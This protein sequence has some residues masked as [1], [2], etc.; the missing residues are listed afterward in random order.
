MYMDEAR[1][2]D[3]LFRISRSLVG[4][5]SLDDVLDQIV[6]LTADLVSSKICALMLLDEKGDSLVIK[7][8]QSLSP[9]YK[10]KLPVK[11]GE[12]IS[13]RVIKN[14]TPIQVRDVIADERYSYGEVARSEGLKSLLSVPMLVGEIPIGV[15]NCYTVDEKEFTDTEIKLVQTIAN[16]A[17][18]SIEHT[19]IVERE[20][21]ARLAL[22]TRKIVDQAKRLLM[23]SSN[24][25]E[26]DAYRKIQK[27]S[28][29]KGKPLK[30]I[31]TAML[32]A[33]EL[34]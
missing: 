2:L 21:Q 4:K 3:T 34:S 27:L 29:A 30:D 12:S 7:A 28:M 15:L 33:V 22:E 8:T 25:S 1:Q 13:G 6:N 19:R 31:A 11:V 18:M 24:L 16:Q 9:A 20:A 14:R 17:A 32:L 23:K 26:E 5:Q 10:N